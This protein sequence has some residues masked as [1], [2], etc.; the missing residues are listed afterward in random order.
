[1][2]YWAPMP[3]LLSVPQAA[4]RL[5][6]K[7]AIVRRYC[8]NGKLRATK[9]TGAWLIFPDDLEKFASKPRRRGPKSKPR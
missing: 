2:R 7:P 5:G 8:Q 3:P 6:L 1:M 4:A 9:I